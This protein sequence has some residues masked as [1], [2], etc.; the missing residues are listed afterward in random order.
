[1]CVG[2]GG[3]CVDDGGRCAADF[4]DGDVGWDDGG[5]AGRGDHCG[6]TADC[7]G[8]CSCLDSD[9]TSGR[10]R[11]SAVRG[12]DLTIVKDSRRVSTCHSR[13]RKDWTARL[14]GSFDIP[15]T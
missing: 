2:E 3:G 14:L 9:E 12:V 8:I 10:Y 1:V 11:G 5:V 15:E 13:D 6:D 4:G 7:A